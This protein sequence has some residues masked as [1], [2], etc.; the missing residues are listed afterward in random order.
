MYNL[1]CKNVPAMK[2]FPAKKRFPPNPTQHVIS[3]IMYPDSCRYPETLSFRFLPRDKELQPPITCG[4]DPLG[5]LSSFF[6]GLLIVSL[7]REAACMQERRCTYLAICTCYE[8]GIGHK[9]NRRVDNSTPS[10][11]SVVFDD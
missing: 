8:W 11:N 1:S 10:Y 4:E 7:P 3:S 9:F 6:M 5:I 2:T